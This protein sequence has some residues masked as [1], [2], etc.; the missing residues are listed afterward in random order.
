[1]NLQT[2][3]Y[4]GTITPKAATSFIPSIVQSYLLLVEPTNIEE[5]SL[6]SLTNI[7]KTKDYPNY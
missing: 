2:L 6:V 1:M 7:Y 4:Y 5:Y 3:V